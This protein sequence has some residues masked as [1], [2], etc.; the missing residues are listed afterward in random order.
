MQS[1]GGGCS[2]L[3][4]AAVES[5]LGVDAPDAGLDV[6]S[7]ILVDPAGVGSIRATSQH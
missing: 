6:G 4:V 1:C 3:S 5:L 7:L 2:S